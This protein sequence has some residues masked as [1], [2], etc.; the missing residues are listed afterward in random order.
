MRRQTL[1]EKANQ[2]VHL[3]RILHQGAD[4]LGWFYRSFHRLS[5]IL[6]RCADY[7]LRLPRP[8]LSF[9]RLRVHAPSIIGVAML[10]VAS[11]RRRTKSGAIITAPGAISGLARWPTKRAADSCS[12]PRPGAFRRLLP[13]IA[14]LALAGAGSALAVSP[15]AVY[16]AKG[17]VATRSPLASEVGAEVLRQGG[18]AV[19]AAVAT[20]FALA[21]THPSAGN[22]GGGGF[23]VIRMADG[24][25]AAND[26]RER[27]PAAAHRDMFLDADGKFQAELS[28]AS[29]LA[30]G[31]PG[32]VDGL[33]TV[34]ARFGSK[35]AAELIA[36]AIALARDGF[37]LPRD[38]ALSLARRQS[39]FA[40]Y[41]GSVKSFRRA[42]GGTYQPG[43]LFRQ[44][45]LAASLQRI[46]ESGR[47]GF[48]EGRTAAL[49]AAEMKRGGGLITEADLAA[50]KSVWREPVRGA[51]RGFEIISMPPPSSGGVMLVQMLNMLEAHDV[52]GMGYGSAAAMHLMIEVERRAYADR[53]EHL[54]DPDFHPVPV[55]RLIDKGYARERL[56]DF[57]ASRASR[58]EDIFAGLAPP[59]ESPETT[60]VSVIDGQGN[61]VAYTTT[62]NLGFGAKIVAEGTGILLNNEMDDFSA[63]P[64]AP[65][66][67]GLVGGEANA[68]EPGKRMLS[69]MTPTLVTRDGEIHLVTGSPGGSTII[70]TTLQV[71][72]NLIDHDM[73]LSQAV[74]RPRFHHQWQPNVVVVEPG[75]SPDTLALLA[76]LGHQGISPYTRGRGIGDANSAMRVQNGFLGM[77]D[78]RN[79]GA[80]VGVN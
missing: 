12:D 42:D 4:R 11:T 55:N 38:L 17:V 37:Y 76:R 74:G 56:A 23:M 16:G 18:N 78:P 9:A 6:K 20:G 1:K 8:R 36:P 30:V 13:V 27:A 32:T 70:T 67:F 45:D 75:F 21:V 24:V 77:S 60:H 40:P 52:K 69:S 73:T 57:D 48:Y 79:A 7:K 41:P 29:H 66:A 65:N 58:S 54:G 47:V 61:A 63:L 22:L 59:P 49:I 62:L 72:V 26:H 53:A 33:L 44:P 5:S 46:Q 50:Y 35:P 43:E 25:L 68:I 28:T 39:D 19:D 51:Y 15:P 3:A 10:S 34:L 80:A 64:G 31:V 71:I 14:V 2:P